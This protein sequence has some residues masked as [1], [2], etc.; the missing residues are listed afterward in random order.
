MTGWSQS[1]WSQMDNNPERWQLEI[2][3]NYIDALPMTEV[4]WLLGKSGMG[5]RIDFWIHNYGRASELI[6]RLSD[7]V[8]H[9]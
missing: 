8:A 2:M 5:C 6:S 1:S 3:L 9:Q 4:D 7:E